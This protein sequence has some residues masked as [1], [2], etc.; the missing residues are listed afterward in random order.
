MLCRSIEKIDKE[1][2]MSRSKKKYGLV[3]FAEN[4]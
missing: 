3:E 1:M 4:P 2:T